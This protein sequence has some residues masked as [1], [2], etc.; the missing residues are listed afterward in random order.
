MKAWKP[1][2]APQAM[3]MEM[4]GPDR[5]AQYRAAAV[6]ELGHGGE[7]DLGVDADDADHQGAEHA[8]LHEAGD[9][10]ARVSSSQTGRAVAKKA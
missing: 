4:K 2:M 6:D 10:A 8:D 1:E 7:L 3:V 9:V 5:A